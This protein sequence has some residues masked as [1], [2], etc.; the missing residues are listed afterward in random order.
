VRSFADEAAAVGL[1]QGG[2]YRDRVTRASSSLRWSIDMVVSSSSSSSS[3]TVRVRRGS[4]ATG[5]R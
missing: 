3:V 1:W 5:F 2:V 4:C